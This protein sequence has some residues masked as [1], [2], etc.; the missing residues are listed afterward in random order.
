MCQSE[1]LLLHFQ[2]SIDIL[3]GFFWKQEQQFIPVF[4]AVKVFFPTVESV[5]KAIFSVFFLTVLFFFM[6][7]HFKMA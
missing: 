7:L 4:R 1:T 2:Q 5:I 6:L 3:F